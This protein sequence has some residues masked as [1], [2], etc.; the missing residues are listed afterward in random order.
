MD[1]TN[2]ESRSRG[3]TW[4]VVGVLLVMLGLSV[5]VLYVGWSSPDDNAATPLSFG[6]YVAMTLGILTTLALGVGLMSLMYYS[7]RHGNDL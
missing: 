3:G 6:G 2:K 7:N 1:N 4:L 5:A